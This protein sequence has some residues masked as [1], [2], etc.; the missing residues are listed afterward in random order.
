[1]AYFRAGTGSIQ[2]KLGTR[3]ARKSGSVQKCI[4]QVT[5]KEPPMAKAR[6]MYSNKIVW[7][8]THSIK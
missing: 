2:D 3:S 5:T 4:P 6:K 7:I 8:M 1:M